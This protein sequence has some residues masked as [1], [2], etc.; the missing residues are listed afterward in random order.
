MVLLGWPPPHFR[1][2]PLTTGKL[3]SKASPCPEEVPPILE[4]VLSSLEHV[5]PQAG[6]QTPQLQ[7]PWWGVNVQHQ[8][9]LHLWGTW[10]QWVSASSLPECSVSASPYRQ[11]QPLPQAG[12]G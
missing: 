8:C 6:G 9:N 12:L 2:G 3:P 4:L 5:L 10:Q 1:Q 7:W 11:L